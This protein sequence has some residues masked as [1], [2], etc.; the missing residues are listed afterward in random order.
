MQ[1]MERPRL[2]L[3]D[4]EPALA[5]FVA[6]AAELCGYQAEIARGDASFRALFAADRPAV[7]AIDLGMPGSDGVELLRFLSAEQFTG[8]VLIISGFERRVLESA[9]RL[10]EALGLNM[11]GPLEKPTRLALL[12]DMLNDL[13]PTLAE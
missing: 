12:E 7:V 13:K 2:L 5:D 4:D 9:F 11:V 3:I 6:K 10:G 1:I 8:P